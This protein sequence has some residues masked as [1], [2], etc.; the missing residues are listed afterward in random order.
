MRIRFLVN[1][2]QIQM[3]PTRKYTYLKDAWYFEFILDNLQ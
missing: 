1:G 3:K 2:V